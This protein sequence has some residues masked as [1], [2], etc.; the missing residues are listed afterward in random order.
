MPS[1]GDSGIWIRSGGLTR[2]KMSDKGTLDIHETTIF[3]ENKR[4]TIN[5]IN[6]KRAS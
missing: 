4:L 1:L 5:I 2:Y 6:L 3:Y